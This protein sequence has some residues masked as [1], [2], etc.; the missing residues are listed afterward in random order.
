MAWGIEHTD[1]VDLITLNAEE[2]VVRLIVIGPDAWSGSD[3]EQ[4]LLKRK[5]D[6]YLRFVQAG[7][8]HQLNPETT[9]H[10]VRFQIDNSSPLPVSTRKAIE[11][12]N[13]YLAE[14]GIDLEI[15]ELE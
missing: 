10:R 4:E 7:E 8:L 15:N 9:K 1:T 3:G 12:I 5:I 2:G 14:F 6:S 13:A 11:R